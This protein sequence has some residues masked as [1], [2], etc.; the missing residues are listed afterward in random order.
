MLQAIG[1][2]IEQYRIERLSMDPDTAARLRV[3]YRIDHGT[4]LAGLLA[5]GA[6]DPEDYLA[7]VLDIPVEQLLCPSL[8]SVASDARV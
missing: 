6:A 4:T 7:F 3:E 1:R 2:R 5:H 8:A